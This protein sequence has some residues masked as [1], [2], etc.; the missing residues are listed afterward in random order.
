MRVFEYDIPRDQAS[1]LTQSI[2]INLEH[3]AKLLYFWCQLNNLF[4][5]RQGKKCSDNGMVW[6]LGDRL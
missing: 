3:F 4:S 5:V 1:F 2:A 6:F